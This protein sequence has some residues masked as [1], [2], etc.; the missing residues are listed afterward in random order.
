MKDEAS[1]LLILMIIAAFVVANAFIYKGVFAPRAVEADVFAAGK[2]EATLL[3]TRS[4]AA[5]LVDTGSDASI[6]RALGNALPPWQRSIDAVILTSGKVAQAGGLP[7][8]ESRY[9]VGAI[10]RAGTPDLPY[11]S[12][13]TLDDIFLTITAPGSITL[14]SGSTTLAISSSTPPGTYPL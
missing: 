11:G 1:P 7:S 4:G 2:S 9:A 14:S 8:I 6:L 10:L 13:L 5:I 12:T 3:R